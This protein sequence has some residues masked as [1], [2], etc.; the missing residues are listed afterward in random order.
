MSAKIKY[1]IY[2]YQVIGHYGSCS[3]NKYKS[4]LDSYKVGVIFKY[5]NDG[6]N[7][8][9]AHDIMVDTKS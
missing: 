9:G 2:A 1:F 5:I 4:N 7:F 6:D 3:L 8:N